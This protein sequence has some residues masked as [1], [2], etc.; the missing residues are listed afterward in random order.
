MQNIADEL[1]VTKVSV[2]KAL[3]GQ[4]GISDQL[5]KKIVHTA[6]RLG[7]VLRAGRVEPAAYTFGFVVTK[8]FFLETDRFYNIIH[9]HLNKLCMAAGH[10]QVLIVINQ[11]EEREGV[12]LDIL[13]KEKLDGLFLA[14]QIADSFLDS[15]M[16]RAGMPVVAL[17]F[18]RDHWPA[19]AVLADNYQLGYLATLYLIERGHRRIG[20]VGNVFATSSIADRFFGYVKALTKHGLPIREDW[21][22]VNNNSDTGD[23]TVD[24][25]LPRELPT[26]FVCHCDM[27]AY[28]LK[29]TLERN[30]L[31]VP[32]DVSLVAFD[33]TEIGRT[34]MKSLTTFDIGRREIADTALS[35]MLRRLQGD[36]AQIGRHY[37][38]S[39]LVEGDTVRCIGE[40]SAP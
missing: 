40:P 4:P 33:N 37:V 11:R 26:G 17:D 9:Y 8:R 13:C 18:Y 15:L 19:D 14:G 6:T 34:T 21:N 38:H 16:A 3:N 30:G 28:F 12:A 36:T 22:L 27:A 5:R 7:Y 29:S 1:G 35:L 2:S 10:G 31:Q 23:Y 20:F 39:K 24:L 25:A 32:E